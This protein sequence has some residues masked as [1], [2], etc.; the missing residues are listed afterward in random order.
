MALF[1]TNV[2]HQHIM[3]KKKLT[4]LISSIVFIEWLEFSLYMYLGTLISTVFF[5]PELGSSALLLT[6]SIFA[7]S[8]LGRPLG[9]LIFGLYADKHGRRAPLI[10]S[11]VL[12]GITTIGIGCIPSYQHIGIFA[13]IL[14]LSLRLL[15]SF[16]IS[17]EFNNAAIYLMEHNP[18]YT[19]LAG[20]WIGTASSAG[21][22]IGGMTAVLVS[23]S[24]FP[25]SWRFAYIMV[26]VVALI[27]MLLRK[28]LL[29]SPAYQQYL[30]DSAQAHSYS[31]P[32][33]EHPLIR[34]LKYHKVSLI[35]ITLMAAFLN[36]YIYTCNIYFV[37]FLVTHAN[38][39]L[40]QATLYMTLVQAAVTLSIPI[41]A[42]LAE[43]IGYQRV[44]TPC[45]I[46]MSITAPSL[47]YSAHANYNNL[48]LL[49]FGC[50]VIANSGISA[51]LF[52]YL[53][54][55]LPTEVRCTGT[56]LMWSLSAA[57][58]GGTSPIL[59]AYFI[60]QNWLVMPGLYVIFFALLLL[61]SQGINHAK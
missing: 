39:P 26:G 6:Y 43:Y 17:G 46:L 16:A 51:T 41:F 2:I 24:H 48:L 31:I 15:Q 60:D 18:I 25:Q 33:P 19:T 11:A 1:I 50:Y 61:L 56:S 12:I 36:V 8:Y 28:R 21:M 42:L 44:L 45:I 32:V 4:L 35:K 54:E 59:A 7:I 30:I 58:F 22:F 13:P 40:Q 53:F 20:S 27:V 3:T 14:L 9:G 10:L 49:S 29:E 57:L 23:T 34:L 5:P 37:S 55:C 52:R 38:Y 47:F